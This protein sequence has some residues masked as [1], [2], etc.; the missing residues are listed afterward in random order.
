[1]DRVEQLREHLMCSVRRDNVEETRRLAYELVAAGGDV[2]EGDCNDV[3]ALAAAAWEGNEAAVQVLA[4]EMKADVNKADIRGW[5]PVAVAADKGKGAVVRLLAGG[6]HADVD[7][8][9]DLGATPLSEAAG[10][11]DNAMVWLLAGDFG[12][13]VNKADTL[14]MTPLAQAAW[15]GNEATVVR[16]VLD[17]NAD[18]EKPNIW[19]ATPVSV[20]AR[21]DQSAIV[22]LL[23]GL[24][25]RPSPDWR[26]SWT[27]KFRE[28]I[29]AGLHDRASFHSHE[30]PATLQDWLAVWSRRPADASMK[31][32]LLRQ[33][34][35]QR[36]ID[37][38]GVSLKVDIIERINAAQS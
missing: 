20:A 4:G 15:K 7:K 2:N 36:G 21:F 37:L 14:G 5:T 23:V 10:R 16:L 33:L 27:A 34:A 24:G 13:D 17:F 12:A 22:R 29:T 25:A 32:K 28:A 26:D 19:G 9:D 3:T 31:V 18:M 11:G 38:S 6:F 30:A 8:A 1:M 35:L